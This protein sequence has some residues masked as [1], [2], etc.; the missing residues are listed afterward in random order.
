VSEWERKAEVVCRAADVPPGSRK[1][2]EYRGSKIGIYNVAG[3][4]R[5]VR[6]HCPH[7]GAP[8]CLGRWGGTL[9]PSRPHAYVYSDRVV[10]QCPWH[11]WEFDLGTGEC[12]TDAR[13]RIKTYKVDVVDGDIVVSQPRVGADT[14][15]RS[16]SWQ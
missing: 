14:E 6:N 11:Q 15:E 12:L 7:M 8:L 5:A 13:A 9:A 10:V 4:Y 16:I 1:L 3:T 2:V